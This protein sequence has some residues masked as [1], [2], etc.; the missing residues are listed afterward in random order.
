VTRALATLALAS[1]TLALSACAQPT[2]PQQLAVATTRALY[3]NN[4]DGTIAHF[5]PALRN[6]V[7]SGAVSQLSTT[8]R[9]L[10]AMRGFTAVGST[11][12]QGRY[13]YQVAFDKGRMLVQ[14]KLDGDRQIAAYRI[15]PLAAQ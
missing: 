10:G 15:T 6:H 11:P 1:T 13:D 7:T 8:L 14:L 5:D 3:A 4:L 2:G 9:A 12:A